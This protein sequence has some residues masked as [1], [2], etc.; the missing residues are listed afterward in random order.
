MITL[1]TIFISVS[2][3]ISIYACNTLLLRSARIMHLGDGSLSLSLVFLYAALFASLAYEE[4]RLR[5]KNFSL[6][7]SF[8][9]ALN[10]ILDS[11]LLLLPVSKKQQELIEKMFSSF[12]YHIHIIVSSL[13]SE[14]HFFLFFSFAFSLFL[15]INRFLKTLRKSPTLN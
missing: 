8:I 4:K 11:W 10:S 7:V 13:L 5:C 1:Y 9:T 15:G 3:Y 6:L 14:Y 12:L 2:S